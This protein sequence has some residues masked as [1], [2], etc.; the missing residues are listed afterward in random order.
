MSL[1][2]ESGYKKRLARR[3]SGNPGPNQQYVP[4]NSP[5]AARPV[6]TSELLAWRARTAARRQ[7]IERDGNVFPV[8]DEYS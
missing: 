5:L 4:V 7:Q 6:T 2:K 3:N 8:Y 1:E